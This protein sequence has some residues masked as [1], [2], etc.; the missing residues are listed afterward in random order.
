MTEICEILA[1]FEASDAEELLINGTRSMG[2]LYGENHKV[3]PSPYSDQ[4]TLMSVA[5]EFALNQHQRLDPKKPSAGGY[6][7]IKDIRWHFVIPPAA[8]EGP[9]LSF[10]KHQMQKLNRHN[11]PSLEGKEHILTEA[12]H[13]FCPILICGETGSGKTSFLHFLLRESSLN[14]RVLILEDLAEIPLT[15]PLWCRLLTRDADTTGFGAI[16]MREL[17]VQSLRLRPD[18]LVFGEIRSNEMEFYLKSYYAGHQGSLATVHAHDKESLLRRYRDLIFLS[19]KKTLC[20]VFMT[21]GSP[22][23]IRSITYI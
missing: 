23:E 12:L 4:A 19:N 20:A 6:I 14:K 18:R 15:G 5:Q 8:P 10:R 21:R 22:P 16:N 1:T 17:F 9:V 7:T 11:F 2:F 3:A 13:R